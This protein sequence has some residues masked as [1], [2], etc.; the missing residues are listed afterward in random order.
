MTLVLAPVGGR[1]VAAGEIGDPVFA[2]EMVGGCLGIV[3]RAE[4]GV[5]VAPVTG[6]LVKAMPHAYIVTDE[7]GRA[8]LV[9]LGIGTVRLEGEHFEVLIEENA[10][11][12][13]GEEITRWDVPAVAARG[14]DTTVVVVRLDSAPGSV[15][16]EQV[17][18][19]VEPGIPLF[20][21]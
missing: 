12:Q 10:T 15:A 11:V 13:A 9:H 6:T 2:Q 17:G 16:S 3:P 21:L 4:V 7:Q 19:E 14:I 20:G 8:V 1:V 18:A 5:A